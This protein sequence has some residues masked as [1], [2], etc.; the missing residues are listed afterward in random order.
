MRRIKH[1]A[2]PDYLSGRKTPTKQMAIKEIIAPLRE[3]GSLFFIDILF[4]IK[5]SDNPTKKF[6]HMIGIG[7]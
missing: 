4:P 6:V 7:K 2:I 1:S 5:V 3:K